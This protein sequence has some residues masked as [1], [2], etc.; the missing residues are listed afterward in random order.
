[1]AEATLHLTP[2]QFGANSPGL[3]NDPTGLLANADFKE[4]LMGLWNSPNGGQ[5]SA[6]DEGNLYF[7]GDESTA[8]NFGSLAAGDKLFDFSAVG[9][10]GGKDV[11]IQTIEKE[12]LEQIKEVLSNGDYFAL[13]F[14]YAKKNLVSLGGYLTI[15]TKNGA[16][17]IFST[18]GF[19]LDLINTIGKFGQLATILEIGLNLNAF[20]DNEISS[21][22]L[23]YGLTGNATSLLSGVITAALIGSEAGPIGTLVGITIGLA[24]PAGE[25]F[26]D[27]VIVPTV[28]TTHTY[29]MNK[30]I[31]PLV[32]FENGL[33]NW[34]P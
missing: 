32:N 9:G 6:D 23:A 34:K 17:K 13:Q 27:Q 21:A 31:A 26:Y 20:K 24:F 3:Y 25:A 22:R 8:T 30:I 19:Y 16:L 7:Y 1:M 14:E 5:W 2:Y 4:I 15:T 18:V 12:Q 29:I 10:S 28:N 11:K 33:M